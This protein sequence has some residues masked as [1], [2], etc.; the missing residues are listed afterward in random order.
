MCVKKLKNI[1]F[2]KLQCR[3]SMYK[4]LFYITKNN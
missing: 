1:G 4:N 3:A 2:L